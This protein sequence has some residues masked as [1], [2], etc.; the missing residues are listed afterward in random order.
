MHL[1]SAGVRTSHAYALSG[2]MATALAPI[3]AWQRF[4]SCS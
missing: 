3:G 1:I 2:G 4:D